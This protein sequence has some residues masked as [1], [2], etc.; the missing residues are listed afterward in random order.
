M[1]QARKQLG[2]VAWTFVTEQAGIPYVPVLPVVQIMRVDPGSGA[3]APDINLVPSALATVTAVTGLPGCW[4]ATA[5]FST[6]MFE[7]YWLIATFKA[8][9]GITDR[10]L[11][12]CLVLSVA[13]QIAVNAFQAGAGSEDSRLFPTIPIPGL[14]G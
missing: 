7:Q 11:V 8:Q 2:W 14:G 6:A 1:I 4:V 13:D 5:D 12:E 9:D 3:L 10:Q